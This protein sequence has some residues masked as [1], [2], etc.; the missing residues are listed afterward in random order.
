MVHP[1]LEQQRLRPC[2][3]FLSWSLILLG[4]FL[5][6]FLGRM[7]A[8]SCS[9]DLSK[10]VAHTPKTSRARDVPSY[11]M[12]VNDLPLQPTSHPGIHK[13][14]ILKSFEVAE[15]LA[16]LSIANIEVGKTIEKHNHPTMFEFFY[17]LSGEGYVELTPAKDANNFS[18]TTTT[19]S[20]KEVL[21][22]GSFLQTAPGDFHSFGVEEN[23]KV[24]LRMIYFGVT[25]D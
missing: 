11:V 25:T 1:S 3:R 2:H 18:S 7:G 5:G 9:F 13:Q 23:Q 22:Q 16:A 21:R 6:F 17:I 8:C 10:H 15:N 19:V 14:V 20:R 24:P 12:Q 4:I